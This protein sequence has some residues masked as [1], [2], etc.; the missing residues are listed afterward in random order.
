MF[1]HDGNLWIVGGEVHEVMMT[2]TMTMTVAE[3]WRSADGASWTKDNDAAFG[4]RT[5]HRI[6]SYEGE[7]SPVPRAGV[8]A[9]DLLARYVRRAGTAAPVTLDTVNFSGGVGAVSVAVG[10]VRLF[11]GCECRDGTGGD[12]AEFGADG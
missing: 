4:A 12:C 7:D 6:L 5:G 8:Q 10:G 11:D 2:M 9:S 3:V 1:S